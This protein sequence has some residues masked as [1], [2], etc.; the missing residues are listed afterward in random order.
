M[1]CTDHVIL[2]NARFLFLTEKNA[3]MCITIIKFQV[4]GKWPLSAKIFVVGT[5]PTYAADSHHRLR[6]NPS[7]KQQY[8]NCWYD[9][10]LCNTHSTGKIRNLLVRCHVNA[11]SLLK[12]YSFCYVPSK[13]LKQIMPA[14]FIKNKMEN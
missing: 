9:M 7:P 6:W 10:P 14:D 3:C 8:F 4:V 2:R 11:A 12:Q 5:Q 13:W 1:P